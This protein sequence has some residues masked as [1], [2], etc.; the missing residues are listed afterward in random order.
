MPPRSPFSALPQLRSSGF[1]VVSL[2]P[3]VAL[4]PLEVQA[5]V[6]PAACVG[7]VLELSVLERGQTQTDRFRFALRLE[8]EAATTAAALDQLNQRLE[9]TRTALQGLAQ[10]PLTIPAPRSYARG[11]GSQGPRRQLAST[12]IGGE[13]GRGGYD[14]LIQVAGRL[15]GVRLQ[16]MTSLASSQNQNA[17][18]DQLLESALKQGREQAE[19]TAAALGLRRVTLLRIDQ[20]RSG[21][22]RPLAYAANAGRQFRPEEAPQPSQSLALNLDYCLS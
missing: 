1:A 11:G 5:Q 13:V 21:A 10:G 15:P 22:V 12:S 19:R 20:R 2:L 7:T 9:A 4:L 16:G 8:A 14:Q 6:R 18:A 3:V 17:L